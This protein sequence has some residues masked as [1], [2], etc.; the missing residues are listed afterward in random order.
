[1]MPKNTHDVLHRVVNEAACLPG[2]KFDLWDDDGA[3]R[4]IIQ[5]RGVDNYDH[6]RPFVVNHVHPVPM[7]TYNERSW[8]RWLYERCMRTMTH[9]LGESLRFGDAQ[10]RPFAPMH[11]PGE[12]P[13]TVHETRPEI[14]ALTTQDGSVRPGPV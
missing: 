14:D 9:E 1:M 3:L 2:W 7:T 5:I 12:D 10:L 11:G 6:T 13:Y 8:Q 4:L